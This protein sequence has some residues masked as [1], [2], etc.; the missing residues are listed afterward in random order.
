M[1]DM[2]TKAV[3][4][5]SRAGLQIKKHSPEILLTVGIAGT[6]TGTVMAC[7]AT[8]KV[9]EILEK[10]K[11]SLEDIHTVSESEEFKDQYSQEDAK[12]DTTIVYT[13]TAVQLLKLYAPSVGVMLLSFGCIISGHKILSKRN[14]IL[15]S[16]YAAIDTGFK[17]YRK[18]VIERFGEQVDKELKYNIKAQEIEEEKNGKVKKKEV[19]VISDEYSLSDVSPY[20]KFFDET[21]TAYKK[22]SEYNLMFLRHQQDFA[23]EKLKAQGH[24]FLN[25]VYEM[26]GLQKTKF[27]QLVG[28]IYDPKNPNI[29]SYVDFNI[30][31]GSRPARDFV[32]GLEKAILLDFNVDG[33]M[34]DLI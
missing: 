25:D 29:D 6:I 20:A 34:Y 32:N 10:H 15:A 22:D 21:S 12:K 18:N 5:L 11:K 2:K 1:N 14:M 17:N 27:G 7:K 30:Y 13:Q 9:N 4:L 3:R 24:L 26:L 8:T 28:W 16:A 31:N 19:P 33:V 23:N